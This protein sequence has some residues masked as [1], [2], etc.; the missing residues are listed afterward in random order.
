MP[1]YASADSLYRALDVTFNRVA[2]QAPGSLNGLHSLLASRMILRLKCSAP[3]AEITLNGR[4]KNLKTIWG[5]STLRAD[6]T[7]ELTSD[8]L[9]LILLNELSIKKA[10]A[11]G[12]IK[13][14]GPVWKL[15]ALTDLVKGAREFYPDVVK[16]QKRAPR[17]K[18]DAA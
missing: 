4:E 18:K 10:W 9:H 1:F 14:Q 3:A 6:L 13:V 5:P 8:N 15:K 16:E 17:R 12:K 7:V 2:Q 11:D